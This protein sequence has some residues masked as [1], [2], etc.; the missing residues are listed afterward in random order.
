MKGYSEKPCCR[1][2]L[3]WARNKREWLWRNQHYKVTGWKGNECIGGIPHKTNGQNPRKDGIWTGPCT[4]LLTGPE[5]CCNHHVCYGFD[6]SRRPVKASV[7][8]KT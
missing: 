8:Q 4:S 3:N 7:R 5:F 6:T 1:N 2:C